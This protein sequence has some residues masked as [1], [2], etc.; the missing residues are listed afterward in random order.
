MPVLV[1][2][3]RAI[4]RACNRKPNVPHLCR[5]P[6]QF[7]ESAAQA[8][9]GVLPPLSVFTALAQLLRTATASS[10]LNR[11]YVDAATCRGTV[12]GQKMTHAVWIYGHPCMG[13]SQ[14]QAAWALLPAAELPGPQLV[15]AAPAIPAQ[16][17]EMVWRCTYNLRPRR[18]GAAP[19][20]KKAP[21]GQSKAGGCSKRTKVGR[22]CTAM[23]DDAST[24]AG[25]SYWMAKSG[26]LVHASCDMSC[27]ALNHRNKPAC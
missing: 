27:P 25:C 19:A 7:A 3:P 2:C 15:S 22:G 8:A 1:A 20:D 13:D 9:L 11:A 21:L 18:R 10:P 16:H 17:H 24:T 14:Q 4:G 26:W 23:H 6:I 5:T 12:T